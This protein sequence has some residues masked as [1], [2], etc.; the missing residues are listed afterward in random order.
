MTTNTKET[1]L[2][3]YLRSLDTSQEEDYQRR[4]QEIKGAIT[5]GS[6]LGWLYGQRRIGRYGEESEVES[7]SREA[8]LVHS[9]DWRPE[10]QWGRESWITRRDQTSFHLIAWTVDRAGRIV[11]G[12]VRHKSADEERAY[13]TRGYCSCPR[14]AAWMPSVAPGE[15]SFPALPFLRKLDGDTDPR[16][17]QT[18]TNL[19][20]IRSTFTGSEAA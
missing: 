16:V 17:L 9:P 11:R 5:Y 14:E 12:W 4:L 20:A 13:N 3:Q 18:V 8:R 1:R 7:Y 2:E 19:L 6:D 15:I 10:W